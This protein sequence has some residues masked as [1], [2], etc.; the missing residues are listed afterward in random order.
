M[1]IYYISSVFDSPSVPCYCLQPAP[2]EQKAE[3]EIK[4][5][6]EVVEEVKSDDTVQKEE[7]PAEQ[8]EAIKGEE[9]AT[10]VT[11]KEK[12]VKEKKTEKKTEKKAEE[13]KG[14][15]RLKTMQCKVTLLDD[16]QFECELDVRFALLSACS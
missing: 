5:E 8:G 15:K 11:K 9:K 6:P 2:E 1:Y 14:A 10:E 4:K 3:S 16:A 7:E 13:P 12:P